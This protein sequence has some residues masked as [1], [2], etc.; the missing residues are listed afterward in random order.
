MRSYVAEFPDGTYRCDDWLDNDGIVDAPL[1]IALDLKIDGEE[2]TFDFS[3]S[4]KSCAGPVNISRSTAIASCYVALQ[5]RVGRNGGPMNDR[6]A[7][8]EVLN[9]R[10]DPGYETVRRILRRRWNFRNFAGPGCLIEKKHVGE[11]AADI[12]AND[13]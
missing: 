5:Q 4:A 13:E 3:R 6:G 7:V 2:L 1:A 9:A 12:D 10:F 8:A 11:G